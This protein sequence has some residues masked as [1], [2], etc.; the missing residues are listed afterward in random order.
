MRRLLLPLASLVALTACTYTRGTSSTSIGAGATAA[1]Q[2]SASAIKTPN[3]ILWY[4]TAA[5]K[6]A[7]Y[8][9]A[10]RLAGERVAALSAGRAAGTWAVIL[11][12]DE[13]VLDNSRYQAERAAKGLGYDELSWAEWVRRREATALPGAAAFLR[14]VRARGGRVAIV[15]NRLES[16]CDDT[17]TNLRSV[18]LE[19]DIVLCKGATSDK[20]PRFAQVAA[21][22]GG[23][24]PLEVLLWVGDNIQDFPGLSQDV[25]LA[26]EADLAR[27]GRSWIILPNPMYGSW[28]RNPMH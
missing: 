8:V 13:T 28:E 23:L 14:A 27:I 2:G 3:D 16:E 21:G 22:V 20:N 1:V 9:Q 19:F 24:P 10:Y 15:T 25:R 18:N 17:R 5:E 26:P 4:H 6:R 12:A 11:D 7:A